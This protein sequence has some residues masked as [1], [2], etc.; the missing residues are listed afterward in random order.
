MERGREKIGGNILQG[1]V[2]D[3]APGQYV[4]YTI[5]DR[6]SHKVEIKFINGDLFTLRYDDDIANF[7]VN[8][9]GD[10][11]VKIKKLRKRRG[12]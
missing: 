2:K 9:I 6:V 3:Y 1:N 7:T 5:L 10:G 11:E 12:T 8:P 4:K